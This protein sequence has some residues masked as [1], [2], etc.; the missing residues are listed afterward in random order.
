VSSTALR[1]TLD[2]GLLVAYISSHSLA[3]PTMSAARNQLSGT[4]THVR[5]LRRLARVRRWIAGLVLLSPLAVIV[6]VDVARRS[7]QFHIFSAFQRQAYANA[8][9]EAALVWGVLLYAASRRRGAVA[10]IE[11]ALFVLGLGASIGGQRYFHDQYHVYLTADVATFAA[12]LLP[13]VWNQL[14]AD[15]GNY[16]RALALPVLISSGLLW[17]ARKL[18]RP[19]RRQARH[20]A[21]AAP[22]LLIGA[23][24]LPTTYRPLQA[25]T[26]DV[27]YLNAVGALIRA[28]LGLNADFRALTPRV[29]QSLPVQLTAANTQGQRANIVLL[30]LESVRADMAC[31]AAELPCTTTPYSAALTPD[32]F[33]LTQL[34]ALDSST[35]IS[36]A[37]LW[38][39]ISPLASREVMHS[40]PLLFDYAKARG[41]D[42][43]FFTSQNLLFANSRQWVQNLGVRQMVSATD[44]DPG[45]DIDMG[46]PEEL[47]AQHIE[48]KVSGLAEPYF[49]VV[50]FSNTHI[51]YRVDPHG[52]VP[53]QPWSASHAPDAVQRKNQY[54]NA[55]YQAD[56]HVARI[57]RAFREQPAG[58]RTVIVY[59]SDH[60]EGLGDHGQNGH[61]FTVFDEEIHVPGWIDAPRGIL[62]DAQTAQL[63]AKRDAYT[64]HVDL[65]ATML[66]LMGVWDDPGIAKFRARMLG[67]SL[68]RP[69]A[70]GRAFALTNCAS[71]WSCGVENWGYMRD[72]LKLE[73]RAWV[74]G[75]GCF[76]LIDDPH[77]QHSLDSA[78]CGDLQRLALRSF[79]RLPGA[80]VGGR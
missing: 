8:A 29:R 55:V 44:L 47:L 21:L 64:Y 43:A 71:V 19:R 30:I 73:A 52:P 11:G 57:V 32:R 58:A 46:A 23:F 56:R 2:P 3:S 22:L 18:L 15:I 10:R 54:L 78:H 49:V 4:R 50:Q 27:L 35:A 7:H 45:A 72:R 14:F 38:S 66:D 5:T 79:K 39:G 31:S 74:P 80:A 16:L 70:A 9:V 13:S 48:A 42:T 34:R 28:Q 75:W 77:E 17:A 63:H 51:P 20:A 1:A 65:T 33:P 24:F 12:T 76:D 69:L 61:T 53:F 36:L 6:S 40:W 68:L 62:T 25:S 41:Y 37:V 26:P 67:S 60:G 59:T